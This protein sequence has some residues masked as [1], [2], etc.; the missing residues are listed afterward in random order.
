MGGGGPNSLCDRQSKTKHKELQRSKMKMRER[1]PVVLQNL[2]SQICDSPKKK[3]K[4]CCA[5]L[6]LFKAVGASMR[7]SSINRTY[8]LR[9]PISQRKMLMLFAST[10][11]GPSTKHKTFSP[12]V[13]LEP[14][15]KISC[16]LPV[17]LS[18][19]CIY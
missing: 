8:R 2:Q 5:F 7:P 11:K 13:A 17:R 10:L 19:M 15:H 16:C 6:P 12:Y 4:T 1:P 9:F 18:E 14:L 3:K